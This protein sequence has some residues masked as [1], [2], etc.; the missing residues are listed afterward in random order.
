MDIELE[1]DAVSD[2]DHYEV[3]WGTSSGSYTGSE[4]T[5]GTSY[6]LT[7]PD[8]TYYFAVK[9]VG[10]GGLKSDYSREVCVI[11]PNN[12]PEPYDRGWEVTS[13]D[14]KGAKFF[15]DSANPQTPTLESSY[16]IPALNLS[17]V[18]PVGVRMNLQ[19]SG[20]T[21]NPHV[22]IF[23]PCPGYSDVSGLDM[24]YYND[25]SWVLANDADDPDI[26]QPD[27][28]GWMVPGS[29]ENHHSGTPSTIAIQV[30]HFSG[31]Q[32]GSIQGSPSS[33]GSRESGSGCFLGTAAQP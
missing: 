2:A 32:A 27:A 18:N 22:T 25:T 17:G 28:V 29:R 30:Y 9:A 7:V 20:A 21:F 11:D 23:V 14:L 24:Y 13:G 15:Y 8:V 5:S 4:T 1:W 16:G 19:P 31:V 26:V 6:N 10:N 33:P 3:Y 12:V